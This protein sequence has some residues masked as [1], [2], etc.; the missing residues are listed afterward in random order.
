MQRPL[1]DMLA[2]PSRKESQADAIVSQVTISY[3]DACFA[4][5]EQRSAGGAS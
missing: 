4:G 1:C 3:K 2:H 5:R